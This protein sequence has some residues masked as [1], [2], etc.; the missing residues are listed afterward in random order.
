MKVV[1]R[2]LHGIRS[3]LIATKPHKTNATGEAQGEL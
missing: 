2:P 3:L 1:Y